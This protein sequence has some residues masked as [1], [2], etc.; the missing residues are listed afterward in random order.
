MIYGALGDFDRGLEIAGLGLAVAEA[1]MPIFQMYPLAVLARLRLWQSHL[2]EAATLV[3]R[4][5]QDPNQEGLGIFR[6]LGFQAEAE[7]ALAL[8]HY[9]QAGLMA[10][11]AAGVTRQIG[12]RAY[13]PYILYLQGQACL[14]LGNLKAA[15]QAFTQ[16][17]IEAEALS[18]RRTWW[19]I[20]AA[21]AEIEAQWGNEAKAAQLRREARTILDYIIA[22]IPESGL[23]ATFL[24]LPEVRGVLNPVEVK[25]STC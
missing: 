13:L 20:L 10:E 24:A 19:K 7:L 9:E 23:Q 16:A 11:K 17:R 1:R 14:G 3:E 25:R 18:A 6:P 8:S 15:H 2:A 21:L 22:H 5:R 4:M 12:V